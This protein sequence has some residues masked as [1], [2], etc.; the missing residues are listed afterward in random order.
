MAS[1][2]GHGFVNLVARRSLRRIIAGQL[3]AGA[4]PAIA[5]AIDAAIPGSILVLL[6]NASR[7]SVADRPS[8]IAVL[9]DDF[10]QHSVASA[11]ARGRLMDRMRRFRAPVDCSLW[12]ER[13]PTMF[14]LRHPRPRSFPKRGFSRTPKGSFS[15]RKCARQALPA[16]RT[17]RLSM[18]TW[19]LLRGHRESIASKGSVAVPFR[20]GRC[21]QPLM[22][23]R[24]AAVISLPTA[25]RGCLLTTHCGQSLCLAS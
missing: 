1:P 8:A 16:A 3:D 4:P 17:Y 20:P 10:A 14:P 24:F 6:D 18:P 23:V 11:S 13:V 12:V 9:T 22:N 5:E 21:G 2:Q 25:C 7:L 15:P 19:P